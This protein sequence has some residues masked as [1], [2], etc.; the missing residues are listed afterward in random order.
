MRRKFPNESLMIFFYCKNHPRGIFGWNLIKFSKEIPGEICQKKK[1][2][3]FSEKSPEAFLN[4][5]SKEFCKE[6]T[7]EIPELICRE[8]SEGIPVQNFWRSLCKN[9]SSNPYLVFKKNFCEISRR[10]LSGISQEI[11]EWIS[12][13]SQDENFWM[14]F[15]KCF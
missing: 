7:W 4:K 9:F 5:L 1:V 12:I 13:E 15:W 6:I 11:P 3:R 10:I 14:T 2:G 8:N